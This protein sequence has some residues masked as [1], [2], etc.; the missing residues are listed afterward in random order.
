VIAVLWNPWTNEY[1][2]KGFYLSTS[3]DLVNWTK[4]RLVATLDQFLAQEPPELVVRLLSLIDPAA[5]DLNFSIVG[6]HSYL[7]YV[8]FNSDGSSACCSGRGSH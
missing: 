8:R 5:P 6:D 4:P 2:A 3:T 1:G 7:Y